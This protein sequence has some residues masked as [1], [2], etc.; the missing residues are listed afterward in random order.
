MIPKHVGLA[1]LERP[2]TASFAQTAAACYRRGRSTDGSDATGR[3]T[4]ENGLRRFVRAWVVQKRV[5]V[6]LLMREIQLRWGRRNLGFAWLF[7]EPLVFAFPV[8]AMWSLMRRGP[9]HGVPVMAF[10]WSGYLPLLMFRHVTGHSLNTI[11]AGGG[12]LYH[13]AITPLDL[14]IAR[15]GLEMIGNLAA[16]ALSFLVFYMIGVVEWPHDVSLFMLG[17]FYMAW[18]SIAMALII[19]PLSE[20][21]EIV[22]HVWQPISYMYLPISG[23]FYLAAWMPVSLRNVALT[24]LPSLHAYEMIRGGLFGNRIQVFYDITYVT[25][26]LA[27]LTLLGLWLVHGVRRHLQFD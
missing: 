23:F 17:L 18:W 11:R 15:F 2:S 21:S 22:V 16:T 6:A 5:I 9:E 20:R 13:R 10:L 1:K 19:A 26:L 25:F 24:V 27:V 14:L 12:L 4:G 8:L 7:V 3:Q